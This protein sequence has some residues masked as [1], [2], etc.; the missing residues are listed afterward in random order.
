MKHLGILSEEEYKNLNEWERMD[1]RIKELEKQKQN[2]LEVVNEQKE[3][4]RD[5]STTLGIH[6]NFCSDNELLNT[7][8]W[9]WQWGEE[10]NLDSLSCPVLIP[11]EWLRALLQKA[12]NGESIK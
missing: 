5:L 9:C 2:L 10:N 7:N 12:K 6:H 3:M 8:H 11:A 1:R 4:I